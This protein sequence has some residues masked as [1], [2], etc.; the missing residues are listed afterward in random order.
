MKSLLISLVV[1]GSFSAFAN[2]N[3]CAQALLNKR[4]QT[5]VYSQVKMNLKKCIEWG[6][7]QLKTNMRN[8]SSYYALVIQHPDLDGYQIKLVIEEQ[9]DLSVEI[10]H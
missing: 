10:N 1:L 5:V 6:N 8:S 4:G 7:Q 9:Q 3:T 2:E